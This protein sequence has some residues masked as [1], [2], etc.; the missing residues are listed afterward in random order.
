MS[1]PYTPAASAALGNAYTGVRLDDPGSSAVI[2]DY[3]IV[4]ACHVLYPIQNEI[5]A[6]I[7]GQVAGSQYQK[8]YTCIAGLTVGTPVYLSAAD[9]VTAASSTSDTTAAVIGICYYKPTTTTCYITHFYQK[10][11]AGAFTAGQ[12]LY[13]DTSGAVTATPTSCLV[14]LAVNTTDAIYFGSPVAAV[15]ARAVPKFAVM[16]AAGSALTASTTE[17]RLHSAYSIPANRLGLG[18]TMRIRYQG[19]IT[20]ATGATTLTI[21][22]RLGPTTLTGTQLISGTATTSVANGIFAG[23]FDF[24]PRA[25]AG[26]TAACVGFG[27]Y[28]EPQAAGAVTKKSVILAS[29]NF[30][31]N[32]VLLPELT[33]QWSANDANSCRLDNFTV[34]IL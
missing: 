34:D 33:A 27:E 16:T 4:S 21:R 7:K 15:V 8:T 26:A 13:L 14:G 17:T 10:T 20:N 2:H 29:T 18:N 9:T 1:T 12:S 11:S 32:G 25:A 3:S 28:Q 30:A 6:L 5:L 22:L 24:T 31:T 19:I 23:W